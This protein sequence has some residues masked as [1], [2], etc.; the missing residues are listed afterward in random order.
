MA[1]PTKYEDYMPRVVKSMK[2]LGATDG[3]IADALG[4]KPATLYRWKKDKNKK[5]F[6]ESLKKGGFVYKADA[7]L[8]LHKRITGF[9]YKEKKIVKEVGVI[10]RE[11]ITEKTVI[12]DVA[13]I[14]SYM[15]NV[16]GWKHKS[17]HEVT[18]KDGAPLVGGSVEIYLPDNQRGDHIEKDKKEPK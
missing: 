14:M 5:E 17:S 7:V 13:A 2:I 10:V 4:I 16:W 3:E 15:T 12:P 1:R 9:K 6:C 11:E 8:S 18:G